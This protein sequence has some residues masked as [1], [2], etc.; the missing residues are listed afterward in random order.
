VNRCESKGVKVA[1]SNPCFELWLILHVSEYH[2][3]DGRAA[4][5]VHLE[6]LC[7]DYDSKKGKKPDCARFIAHVQLAEK[8]A[9]KQLRDREDEGNRFGPPSTTVFQLTRAIREASALSRGD[10]APR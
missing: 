2:R 4:V 1:R 9:E 8:R 7:P 6:A 3:P 10:V 5:Q